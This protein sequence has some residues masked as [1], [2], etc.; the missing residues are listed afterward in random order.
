MNGAG[1]AS[2][3]PLP[4]GI[5]RF[6]E[7]AYRLRVLA[8]GL[9]P[10]GHRGR[11][12]GA[13][14]LFDI[15][16]PLT[17]R[18]DPRRIDL[19]ASLRDPFETLLV[20]RDR[21]LAETDVHVIVDSS[22]SMAAI[23]RVDRWQIACHLAAGLAHMARRSGDRVSLTAGSDGAPLHL[24]LNRRRSIAGEVLGALGGMTPGGHR[25][26][27]LLAGIAALPTRPGMVFLIS[28]FAFPPAVT[29]RLASALSRHDL[30][31]FMLA[32]SLLDAPPPRLGLAQLRDAETGR[33]S[34]VLM[35]PALAAQWRRAAEAHAHGLGR[36]FS[37]HGVS[38]VVIRDQID[39]EQVLEALIAE[40][41]AP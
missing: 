2:D 1:P 27:G 37:A 28:D 14:G 20:R 23:G 7:L 12:P 3:G 26:D 6:G 34:T 5:E 29:D 31:P 30:R 19:R 11:L 25:L 24:A 33:R 40:G 38:P 35:R 10:G 8:R 21:M 41:P 22:A 4:A 18:P 15:H 32:D 13:Q 36:V 9:R 17:E 16:V 39:V